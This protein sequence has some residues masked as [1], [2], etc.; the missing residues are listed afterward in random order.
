MKLLNRYAEVR[1]K[2]GGR[3]GRNRKEAREGE[4]EVRNREE[5]TEGRNR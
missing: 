3:E 4:K 2:E 5:G 1:S